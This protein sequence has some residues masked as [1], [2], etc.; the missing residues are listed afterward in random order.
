MKKIFMGAITCALLFTACKKEEVEITEDDSTTTQSNLVE[1]ASN[2]N[3]SNQTIKLFAEDSQLTTGYN[4]LY[5]T[6]Q[7]DNGNIVTPSSISY[8]PLMTMST[9]SHACPVE[10]P[11]YDAVS[12]KYKGALVFTMSSM[13]G[14]WTLGVVVDGVQVIFD[15]TVAGAPTK[16]VGV[17]TG[18]D[19]KVYVVSLLRPVSWEVGMNDIEVLIHRKESM[20]SFPAED[21]FTIQMEPEMIS[22][23]HGSPNNVDPVHIG[24]G[25]YNGDVNFTMTGDW[26]IHLKLN[27]NGTEIHSDAF[28][29]ILF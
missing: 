23:E 11:I 5:V 4:N 14:D 25:H 19:G 15:L 6:V 26:R 29:D 28:L 21:S 12:G 20:M 8:S 16:M 2:V 22:M 9:M 18:T 10:Q 27:Q 7:D 3:S 1:I 17:Y 13:G 24:N